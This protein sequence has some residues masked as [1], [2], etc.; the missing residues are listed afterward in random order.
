[1]KSKA[2]AYIELLT[3]NSEDNG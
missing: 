2:Q 1:V 3:D